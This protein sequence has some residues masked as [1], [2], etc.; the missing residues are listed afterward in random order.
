MS[1]KPRRFRWLRIGAG[2]MLCLA[3]GAAF[4]LW[5]GRPQEFATEYFGGRAL[6]VRV[7]VEWARPGWSTAIRSLRV[8]TEGNETE[9]IIDV[10]DVAVELGR[11]GEARIKSLRIGAVNA[12]VVVDENGA[13]N[14]AWLEEVLQGGDGGPSEWSPKRIVFE[15]ASAH[16]TAP[17][18][19]AQLTGVRGYADLD[20][21]GRYSGW[22][23]TIEPAGELHA[24]Y[25]DAAH[26]YRLNR[27]GINWEDVGGAFAVTYQAGLGESVAE[28]E[29]DIELGDAAT[30]RVIAGSGAIYAGDV[31]YEWM[32]PDIAFAQVSWDGLD[33]AWT[34]G[35]GAWP[36]LSGSFAGNGL[37]L[38]PEKRLYFDGDAGIAFAVDGDA[39]RAEATVTFA[40]DQS[41]A[42]T[43]AEQGGEYSFTGEFT[44]WSREQWMAIVPREFRGSFDT[45]DVQAVSA[46]A[47]GSWGESFLVSGSLRSSGGSGESPF[48][49]S[50]ELQ[51]ESMAIDATSGW[52]EATLADGRIRAELS[53]EEGAARALLSFE[54]VDAAPWVRWL[55]RR[56][57]PETLLA[58]ANGTIELA[59]SA[60]GAFAIRP[61]MTIG[62][63]AYKTAYFE[64]VTIAG[65]GRVD[66]EW[67]GIAF[68][69]LIAEAD[70]F[71]TKLVLSD[72][73][74]ERESQQVRTRA[75]FDFD[76]A[77]A[78]TL[79]EQPDWYGTA[80]LGWDGSITPERAEGVVSLTSGYIGYG[81]LSLPYGREASLSVEVDY[82]IE[83]A[84]AEL[85]NARAA[86][87]GED[88]IDMPRLD[89]ALEPLAYQGE[90][91][92]F[93]KADL[94][95]EMQW[96]AEGDATLIAGAAFQYSDGGGLVSDWSTKLDA[97]AIVL[98]SQIGSLHELVLDATGT[99]RDGAL[100]GSGLVHAARGSV[101]GALLTD[102]GSDIVF[103][104]DKLIMPGLTG[105]VFNG[106]LT[107]RLEA[108]PLREGLPVWIDAALDN[109]DLAILTEQVKP[110]RTTLTGIG[111]ATLT[112]AL[113]GRD[114]ESFHLE[115]RSDENFSLNRALVR[116]LL[117][118]DRL[119]GGLG[120]RQ[121]QRT[122]DKFL[123]EKP[124]RPFDSA[125]MVLDLIG[126]AVTGEADLLSEKTDAYNGL[127][128][129]VNLDID[130]P[131]LGEALRMLEEGGQFGGVDF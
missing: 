3:V 39:Q 6:G 1:R 67:N 115:A 37:R 127:N 107:A 38:G 15:Q 112:A 128:L 29:L 19:V 81:E 109:I 46:A 72:F 98:F 122:V 82:D 108:A 74:A 87:G 59:E 47:Y 66:A 36:T 99:Y 20:A 51:G 125:T 13:H 92:L 21:E 126:G 61:A 124:Q 64:K 53:G 49:V 103:D 100:D 42:L 50:V 12:R 80:Q 43:V 69:E 117:P 52:A 55:S 71:T 17:S 101:A 26:G 18:G 22:V 89:V 113:K 95:R 97:P 56:D 16:V 32:P 73:T 2:A 68:P 129:H 10:R 106:T 41:A 34:A 76:L 48:G 114:P 75:A 25:N 4:A 96:I 83:N 131:A 102:L 77:V 65:E 40:D 7:E 44:D 118:M 78:G 94:L 35:S 105:G 57:M 85:R 27:L 9:P 70:D 45:L 30:V 123:G 11:S 5:T 84:T 79:I 23:G 8:Y 88:R 60:D 120:Q 63:L 62:P 119:L 24:R 110:P 111:H 116:D 58:T 104:S 14:F 93:A 121:A 86:L 31:P 28:G 54:Q 130:A 33:G 91:E 90:V